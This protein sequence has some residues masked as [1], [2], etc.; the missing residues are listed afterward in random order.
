MK[1]KALVVAL[2]TGSLPRIKNNVNQLET[3]FAIAIVCAIVLTGSVANGQGIVT[4]TLTATVQDSTGAVIVG[5]KDH[6]DEDRHQHRIYSGDKCPG[7]L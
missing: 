4:G 1:M 2:I 5:A 7:L 6:G 3:A